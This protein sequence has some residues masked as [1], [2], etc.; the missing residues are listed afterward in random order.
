MDAGDIT[1]T[2]KFKE[3]RDLTIDGRNERVSSKIT[4]RENALIAFIMCKLISLQS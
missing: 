3:D 4:R 2:K 1:I